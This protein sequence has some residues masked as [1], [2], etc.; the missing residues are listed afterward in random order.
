MSSV[1][2]GFIGFGEVA[3]IFSKEMSNKGAEIRVYDILISQKNGLEIIGNRILNNNIQINSLKEVII[4]SDYIISTVHSQFAKNVAK[5]CAQYLK[6]NNFYIDLNSTSPFVKIEI[7]RIIE[8]SKADFV[9]GAILGAVGI[10]G[11]KTHALTTGGKGKEVAEIFTNLGLNF[12]YYSPE[13]GKASMFKMLRSIFSKG[14]EAILLEFLIAGKK[15]GMEKDLWKDII[16]FLS[17]KSFDK[18]AANWMQTHAL[19][20]ERR[21]HEITQVVETMKELGIEPIMTSGTQA[22]FRRSLSLG[23]KENFLKK[24]DS[25]EEVIDFMEKKTNKT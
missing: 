25:F 5:E 21:Y 24:P 10:T 15:A 7:S 16:S 12:S 14:I 23:L 19:A 13:I 17:E 6:P 2:I 8:S 22:F 20:Y 9:E 3:S 11:P 4:N 18:I 1:K